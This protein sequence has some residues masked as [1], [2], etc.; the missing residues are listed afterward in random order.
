MEQNQP[1]KI[2]GI[3]EAIVDVQ[4]RKDCFVLLGLF[5]EIT[6]EEPKLWNGNMIGFGQYEYKYESGR[7]GK[8]FLTGFAPRKSN[9][10]VYLVGNIKNKETVLKE[11]GSYKE[12]SSCL[13]LNSIEKVD[14]DKL[15]IAIEESIIDIKNKYNV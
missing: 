5:K 8:W 10:V 15:R 14:M 3:L 1:D 12:G 6:K 13:Y 11:F 9:I 7:E 2:N 4:K